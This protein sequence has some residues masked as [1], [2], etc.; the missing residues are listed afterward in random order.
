MICRIVTC[1]L[2]SSPFDIEQA[3]ILVKTICSTCFTY[4]GYLAASM[5]IIALLNI[6]DRIDFF[7]Y[8]SPTF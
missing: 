8:N 6:S 5:Q 1:P 3:V 4:K 2:I 7:I